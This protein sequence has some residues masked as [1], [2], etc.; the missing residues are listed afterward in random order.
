M[1]KII[2]IKDFLQQVKAQNL[3]KE[4]KQEISDNNNR[5]MN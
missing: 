1:E 4:L 5:Q 2:S 3:E